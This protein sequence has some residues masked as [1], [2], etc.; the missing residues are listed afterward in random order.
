[1][2]N[3]KMTIGLLNIKMI[4]KQPKWETR[5]GTEIYRVYKVFLGD[6][7]KLFDSLQIY[8]NFDLL[9]VQYYDL[10]KR[11]DKHFVSGADL[12]DYW[13]D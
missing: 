1:M 9:L 5:N 6:R 8:M 2:P 7:E 13:A 4:A 3:N 11:F 10:F 12:E